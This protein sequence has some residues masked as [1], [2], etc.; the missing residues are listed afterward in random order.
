M[1]RPRE[2]E[3]VEAVKADLRGAWDWIKQN[4]PTERVY[5]FGIYT[6]EDDVSS[7]CPFACG[8]EGLRRVAEEYV[9]KKVIY[10]N[11][12]EAM[13]G[14]RWSVPDSPYGHKFRGDR[15]DAV[16]DTRP[17]TQMSDL[18]T[19]QYA[20]EIKARIDAAID[21]IKELDEEGLF[22]TGEQREAIT[23]LIEGSDVSDD[24]LLKPA[25]KLNPPQVFKAFQ[26]LFRRPKLGR[27]SEYGTKG[28]YETM[29]VGCTADER[30][31]AA[32]CHYEGCI[33]DLAQ[34]KR[35]LSR[36]FPSKENA[37]HL[38]GASI[39][40]TGETAAFL[41]VKEGGKG[42]ICILEGKGWKNQR[43]IPLE[44]K[45]VWRGFVGE[46]DGKW[47]AVTLED[48]RILVYG[49]DGNQLAELVGHERWP[50]SLALSHDCSLLASIDDKVG[51]RLWK[52]S[53]WSLAQEIR[54]A[55]GRKVN[56]DPTGNCVATA[57][58][59]GREIQEN[60]MEYLKIWS[61]P[62]GQLVQEFR[63]PGNRLDTA[64]Y[65]PGRAMIACG[66][67]PRDSKTPSYAA[68]VDA[69][70]GAVIR[71]LIGPYE[72]YDDFA[73]LTSRQAIALA[74][75]TQF[76]ARQLVVWELSDP[77]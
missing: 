60:E 8:E 28:V 54:E 32:A 55:R 38:V 41:T 63:F 1:P 66:L 7:L 6:T 24:F 30:L 15:A 23:L 72:S 43:D 59:T 69:S 21:A 77:E 75:H 3:L 25:K 17:P 40:R 62:D 42:M 44:M 16:L 67:H 12:T 9:R 58:G 35:L 29:Q 65:M 51:V 71:R 57:F 50:S 11:V 61:Y 2:T 37:Q 56:F 47:Y 49:R 39:S 18:T 76:T 14:L 26:D 45:P 34:G 5:A 74:G 53:D 31:V 52:T 10:P 27:W 36:P 70:T 48:S 20:R 22:G 13:Q 64:K 19:S 4:H 73:F 46:P 33:F 68:L